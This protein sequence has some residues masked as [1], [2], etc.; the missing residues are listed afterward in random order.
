[1]TVSERYRSHAE[2]WEERS[3]IR[4]R[5]RRLAESDGLGYYPADRQPLCIHPAIL[6]SGEH[7]QR[8]VLLQSFYRYMNDIII[9]E[10]E[11]VSDMALKIAKGRF[12]HP[13]PCVCRQDA[14]SVVVD[15][16]YHAYVAMD[17][18][19]QTEMLTSVK[20]IEQDTEIELSRA[21][22]RALS[23]VKPLFRDG[24]GLIAVAIAENTVTADVAAFSRDSTLKASV[25]GIMADHLADEGRHSQFW[26]ELV[27][28]YW[29]DIEETGRLMLGSALPGFLTDYLAAD[30]QAA[31]DRRLIEALDLPP[32]IR[33]A[34]TGDVVSAYPITRQHPLIGNIRQFLQRTGILDH[35]PTKASLAEYL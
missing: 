7:L 19:C 12:P 10:T 35:A 34:I 6:E 1:M 13:F 14:M 31:Y 32:A 33:S 25:K 20:P 2:T 15:E 5:P 26:V 24:M 23:A 28:L 27:R 21:I 29:A 16:A 4:S 3:S 30:I 17:Y 9:F 11:I 18:V 8:F 22:P